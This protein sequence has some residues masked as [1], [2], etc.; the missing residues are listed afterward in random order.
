MSR[1]E[2]QEVIEELFGQLHAKFGE[3]APEIIKTLVEVL[4]GARLTFPD[5]DFLYRQERNRRIRNEFTG[6]NHEELA[7]RYRVSKKHVRR[8]LL[9]G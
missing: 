9:R 1:G 3:F 4:G 2:N 5:F 6:C 7:I 8:I